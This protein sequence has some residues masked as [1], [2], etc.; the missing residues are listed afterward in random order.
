MKTYWSAQAGRPIMRIGFLLLASS[1]AIATLWAGAGSAPAATV[2][3][4]IASVEVGRAGQRT[5]VRVAGTGPLSYRVLR[6]SD[7]PRLVMDFSN[8]R[9]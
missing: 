4:A 5:T 1:A 8:A 9:L 6:L 3:T 2:T 7:P